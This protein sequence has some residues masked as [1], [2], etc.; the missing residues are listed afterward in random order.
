MTTHLLLL[1]TPTAA[2]RAAE[3]RAA[4]TTVGAHIHGSLG[5]AGVPVIISVG[6][7]IK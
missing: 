2:D 4:M 6:V 3:A 5:T 1:L 7:E